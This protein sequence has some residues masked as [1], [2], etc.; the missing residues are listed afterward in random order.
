MSKTKI[1]PHIV[2]TVISSKDVVLCWVFKREYKSETKQ[3]P[4]N[5]GYLTFILYFG[6]IKIFSVQSL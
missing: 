3:K 1:A 5:Y 2:I 6:Y 4:N